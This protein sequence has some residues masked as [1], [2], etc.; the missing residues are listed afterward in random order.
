MSALIIY[1]KSIRRD[2]DMWCL[3]DLWRAGGSPNEKRPA[4]WLRKEGA[5]F[6]EFVRDSVDV[7]TGHINKTSVK[8][9]IVRTERGKS[10]TGE[11]GSTWAHWQIA[12][13]YA[14]ALSPA[15]HAHV[16]DVYRAFTAGEL[17][18]VMTAEDHELIRF[19]LRVQALDRGDYESVWELE[20]K[21]EFCRLRKLD[22][23]G[24]GI[25]PKPLA[26]AYGRTWRIVLGD[27]VYEAL[28]TRNPHP[29]SGTLHG[30]WL[31]EEALRI[32]KRED[33]VIALVLSRRS[34]RWAEYE[35]EMRSHFRRAPIQMRLLSKASS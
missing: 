31:K 7:P 11:S 9:D 30:Q 26:F 2:G 13:A 25:E 33:L 18:R 3:T 1:G 6:V 4:N 34:S 10:K 17:Q 20:L 28:K 32:A 8:R 19:K 21:L 35:S 24:H 22:W 15:F 14:K 12:L 16:N 5:V 23:D 27:K 29:R